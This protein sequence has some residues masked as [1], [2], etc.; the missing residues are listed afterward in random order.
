MLL[1]GWKVNL[2]QVLMRKISGGQFNTQAKTF[3]NGFVEVVQKSLFFISRTDGFINA[4]CPFLLSVK[5]VLQNL[6]VLGY[7]YSLHVRCIGVYLLSITLLI[8]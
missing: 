1:D 6:L 5:I 2:R 3:E 4:F 7:I 8:S